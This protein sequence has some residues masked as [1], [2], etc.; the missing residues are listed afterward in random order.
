MDLITQSMVPAEN[1]QYTPSIIMV[2]KDFGAAI[3]SQDSMSSIE[4]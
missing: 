1:D 2:G 3:A 4:R